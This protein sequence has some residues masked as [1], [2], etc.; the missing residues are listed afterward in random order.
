[1]CD[2]CW[3]FIASLSSTTGRRW[4]VGIL[5]HDSFEVWILFVLSGQL[6]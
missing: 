5:L 1:M 2:A 3:I 6:S 4:G